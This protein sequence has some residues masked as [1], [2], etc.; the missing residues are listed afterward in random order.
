MSTYSNGHHDQDQGGHPDKMKRTYGDG[1]LPYEDPA[2]VNPDELATF[3]KQVK[4]TDH[5][6]HHVHHHDHDHHVN[7]KV[8]PARD[9]RNIT[10]TD[11]N[12]DNRGYM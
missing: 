7:K 6:H 2:I 11:N 3:P 4:V 12:P 5:H 9:G 1:V 8:T 10:R